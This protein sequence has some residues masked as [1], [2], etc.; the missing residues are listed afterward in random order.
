MNGK[1]I[2]MVECQNAELLDRPIRCRMISHV[3]M[4]NSPGANLH[5]PEDVDKTKSRAG[6]NEEITGNDGPCL[7][8]NERC[9]TPISS[10]GTAITRAQVFSDGSRRHSDPE[11]NKQFVGVAFLSPRW[12]SRGTVYE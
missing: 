9:P 3:D 7:V 5:R 1:S 12:D 4:Q 11:F 2:R 8:V 6:G 10:R